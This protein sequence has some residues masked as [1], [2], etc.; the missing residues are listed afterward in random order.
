MHHTNSND[1]AS[2]SNARA[3]HS[4][5]RWQT[6]FY[7]WLKFLGKIPLA[8]GGALTSR[9]RCLFVV[10]DSP[11]LF[12]RQLFTA[13]RGR[14]QPAGAYR[15][16][17]DG[18]HRTMSRF[19]R[20]CPLLF[21]LAFLATSIVWP[22]SAGAVS[23]S[24]QT[25]A[26]DC[27]HP[28]LPDSNP[29][30]KTFSSSAPISISKAISS[31]TNKAHAQAA[32]S[33]S[34]NIIT[35]VVS[36]SATG[37]SWM[38]PGTPTYDAK[39]ASWSASASGTDLIVEGPGSI[40][41]FQ[42][43][44]PLSSQ[45]N[46]DSVGYTLDDPRYPKPALQGF[47]RDPLPAGTPANSFFDITINAQASVHQDGDAVN[48]A[49]DFTFLNGGYII[50]SAGT[51][52]P[53][54]TMPPPINLNS[55]GTTPGAID[56]S[57]ISITSPMIQLRPGVPFQLTTSFSVQMGNPAQ[58][59]LLSFPG[60]ASPTGGGGSFTSTFEL[61]DPSFKLF[62]IDPST[63][64]WNTTGGGS[65][66]DATNWG[67]IPNGVNT[68]ADFSTRNLTAE[69]TV[70][71]D[72]NFTAGSLRF[73]DTTPSHNWT[74]SPG[75]TGSSLTLKVT[76]GSPII[77][78]A[79]ATTA[80]PTNST[81]GTVAGFISQSATISAPLAG[82]N[83][84]SKTGAGTLIL[85]AANS[86]TGSTNIHH[87]QLILDFSANN[88]PTNDI[89]AASSNLSLGG[90]VNSPPTAPSGGNLLVRGGGPSAVNSQAFASTTIDTG[91]NSIVVEQNG[92]SSVTVNL[93]L[94][95]HAP[96]GTVNFI[97][98]SAG[99]I[100]TT[101]QN[102]N[103]IL[104]G[105]VT[106]MTTVSPTMSSVD[107]A[108]NDGTG[109]IVPLAS[110]NVLAGGAPP[111]PNDPSANVMINNASTGTATVNGIVDINSLAMNDGNTNRNVIVSNG[112]TLRFGPSG[113][114]LKSN[115]LDNL[116]LSIGGG[117]VTA[118]GP[119]ASGG[120]L[121]LVANGANV[122]ANNIVVS[123]SIIDNG[124]PVTVIKTGTGGAQLSGNNAYT[125]GTFV[126]AGHLTTLGPNALGT[127]SV[128]VASGAQLFAAGSIP[129]SIFI[130]GNGTSEAGG[131]GALRVQGNTTVNGVI[132]LQS[133][134]RI[135][136][137]N[138]AMFSTFNGKITGPHNLE[139][140]G[141]AVPTSGRAF[142]LSSAANDYTGNTTI[143]SVILHMGVN[144]AL[145]S[146]PG[147][148]DV[149][150]NGMVGSPTIFAVL[151]LGGKNLSIN[152]LNSVP[153]TESVDSVY[154]SGGAASLTLGNNNANGNFGGIITGDLTVTKV[155]AGTQTLSNHNGYLGT[156][157]VAG[158][159]LQLAIA[160][161]INN[162]PALILQAG[163]T[164]GTGGFN[165]SI[166]SLSVLGQT[167]IDFGTGSS[168][169]HFNSVP[170]WTGTLRIS[171]WT[172]NPLGPQLGG[173]PDQLIIGNGS[174]IT[175]GSI[176]FDGFD[177]G[178]TM[179]G[180]GE[181]V[182][183]GL[184]YMMADFSR[185][186]QVT[187]ADIPIMLTAL[188]DPQAFMIAQNLEPDELITI[189]DVNHDGK[190]DNRDIQSLLDLVIAGG[191]GGTSAV[192]EP[193]TVLLGAIGSLA[194]IAARFQ[195]RSSP[196]FGRRT[197]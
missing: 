12:L 139:F 100:K 138:T 122:T 41:P 196:H 57:F 78:V 9:I 163:S 153:G 137:D 169:L 46:Y 27:G 20:R 96:G 37:S 128:T 72:G 88:S 85:A 171:N 125:G 133:D 188:T 181:I 22:G 42:F 185:D 31:N 68:T 112:S 13:A 172:N 191:G 183:L 77:D 160:N 149:I 110:Y 186:T 140:G 147:K 48:P 43:T 71:L 148:G 3:W 84:L 101:T 73:G 124:G 93:G 40:A 69:A 55:Q 144:N 194:L 56:L 108:S 29:D 167:T 145:P 136:T 38:D 126:D 135:S 67:T 28:V 131:L 176:Q 142:V 150:L 175:L 165:Q 7:H 197:L 8:G 189:G 60:L 106:V 80:P 45:L 50:N 36:K 105:W 180:N 109:N 23:I 26:V 127:G 4:D 51:V 120:E 192:P 92:A 95:T 168:V 152:G 118:G 25:F 39:A 35:G 87:G 104:G 62:A 117:S 184:P 107:W 30:T 156:T 121:N 162:S 21:A 74:L 89:I 59:S 11:A 19:C 161:S 113:G 164:F 99:S 193:A 103:G 119:L 123:S 24:V 64:S 129:Q 116:T 182:P 17:I 82:N 53:T 15:F 190:F 33:A 114:I 58:T 49:I 94:L 6:F 174:P 98:P 54:G 111:L 10:Q 44:I 14:W 187:A 132:T 75:A 166:G 70:T 2:C 134:A 177:P 179:L 86:Y 170:T 65:W 5:S 173:G 141:G 151:D 16:P 155:G 195:R 130:S 76:S 91:F 18:G 158:G 146:G 159:T 34:I 154:S 143:S 102:I 1:G 115:P 32:A 79:N 66:A 61:R 81:G 90:S 178:A 47:K 157:T 52:T 97:L 63:M 83:G